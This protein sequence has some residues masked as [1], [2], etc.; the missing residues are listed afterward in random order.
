M[1]LEPKAA[2]VA[3]KIITSVRDAHPGFPRSLQQDIELIAS[4]LLKFA[5]EAVE[6]A[7]A[8][9]HRETPAF[10]EAFALIKAE[11]ICEG[12]ERAAKIVADAPGNTYTTDCD[13]EQLAASI[14]ATAKEIR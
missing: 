9:A 6:E 5:R 2:E 13:H 4:E 14:R 1:N 8:I 3:E 10:R 11:G 7:V 12:M